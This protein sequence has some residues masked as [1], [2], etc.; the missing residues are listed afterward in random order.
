MPLELFS[1]NGDSIENLLSTL[2]CSD[3]L[4]R[5]LGVGYVDTQRILSDANRTLNCPE[6]SVIGLKGG[7]ASSQFNHASDWTDGNYGT[8]SD[9]ESD[10]EKAAKDAENLLKQIGLEDHHKS[11]LLSSTSQDMKASL[12]CNLPFGR[13]SFRESD[14]QESSHVTRLAPTSVTSTL[15]RRENDDDV[16]LST[17]LAELS[18]PSVLAE[19]PGESKESSIAGDDLACDCCCIC[20]DNA[21]TKC[22]DC[23][24]AQLFCVRCWW[25]MHIDC[26]AERQHRRVKCNPP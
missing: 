16:D 10:D 14:P 11:L 4:P 26:S 2:D 12:K 17:R 9:D 1:E 25:E 24:G 5:K 13:T 23:D 21:T 3:D 20:Y 8:A 18:L 22:L 19:F 7:S 15:V 6:T